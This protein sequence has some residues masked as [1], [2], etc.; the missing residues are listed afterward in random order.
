MPTRKVSA[1]PFKNH[2][3]WASY[4]YEN[5]DSNGGSWGSEPQWDT[6]M[7][8]GTKTKN[9]TPSA[10]W[11][12]FPNNRTTASVKYLG[13][14]T[15]DQPYVPTG[16]A[17][18]SGIHQLVEVGRLRHQW[19]VSRTSR[20]RSRAVRRCRPTC[21]TIAE[22]FLGQHDI[23]FGVQYTKGRGNWQGGYFQ[24][25]VNFLYP[26]RWTQSVDEHAGVVRRH[27][28][29][30]L[31]QPGHAQSVP[32]GAHGGFDRAVLRRSVVDHE[33]PDAQP[34]ACGSIG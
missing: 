24:N 20:R 3:A 23:K 4:H 30:L 32:D 27:R 26:L 17:R 19:R 1:A 29:A 5:N 13:F 16:C 11:Q 22:K 6:T 10:Q 28:A 7:T 33:A 34:R 2:R 9:H 14:W 18:P 21:R 25:Y 15:D 31:Q 8:Y 12:W